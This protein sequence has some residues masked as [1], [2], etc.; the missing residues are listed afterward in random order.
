MTIEY[1]TG[2]ELDE[3]CLERS[4]SALTDQG[5]TQED[6]Y[7]INDPTLVIDAEGETVAIVT[8]ALAEKIAAFLNVTIEE[9]DH[10]G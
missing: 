7:T 10:A 8:N 4:F 9:K 6:V 2:A 1:I 5:A 3:L